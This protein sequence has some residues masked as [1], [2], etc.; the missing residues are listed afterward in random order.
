MTEWWSYTLSDF[1]LFS[2]RAYYRLFERMNG[3]LWPIPIIL[4]VTGGGILLWRGPTSRR[5]KFLFGGLA[6][7][8]TLVAVV[9]LW[10]RYADINWAASYFAG[11]FV[12]ESLLLWWNGVVR[13]NHVVTRVQGR[14]RFAG[15]GLLILSIA[16]YPGL[17][18]LAGR[19]WQQA[20]IFG[21]APD[22]T[23]IG[24]LG[25]LLLVPIHR[26]WL[27]LPIPLL[28]CLIS[29]ATM[30]AMGSP[31]VWALALAGLTT[32]GALSRVVADKQNAEG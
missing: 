8:W 19:P 18:L 12:V 31:E 17:A 13:G 14:A 25:L 2:P 24:T 3:E 29:G 21:L 5:L 6:V 7:A 22:P 10:Q 9:F 20:E 30:L 28:W 11:G 26:R 1:L 23:V 4:M 27:L 32:I 15:T 16:V